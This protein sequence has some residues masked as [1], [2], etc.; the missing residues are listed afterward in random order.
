M[1]NAKPLMSDKFWV[2]EED[3]KKIGTLQALD[4]G[5]IL[6]MNGAKS[7]IQNEELYKKYQIKLEKKAIA[8]STKKAENIVF[9]YPSASVPY[10]GIWNCNLNLPL[11][12]KKP[13]SKSLHCAGYYI[14]RFDKGWVETFCPKLVTLNKYP[15][16]GPFKN[17]VEA[18]AVLLNER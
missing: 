7:F 2:L 13:E 3:G 11:Y 5:Y 17:Q 18:R 9:E 12:T 10:N 15:Y 6:I 1:I 4:E 8:K 16:K 14:I